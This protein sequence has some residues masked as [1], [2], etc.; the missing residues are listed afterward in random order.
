LKI[1]SN[2]ILE[3]VHGEIYSNLKSNYKD[4]DDIEERKVKITLFKMQE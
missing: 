1:D 4:V 3:K 2:K